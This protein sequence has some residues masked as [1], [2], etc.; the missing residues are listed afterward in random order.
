MIPLKSQVFCFFKVASLSHQAAVILCSFPLKGLSLTAN[1]RV[2]QRE[3]VFVWLGGHCM[4]LWCPRKIFKCLALINKFTRVQGWE[5]LYLS[6]LHLVPNW[7]AEVS[8]CTSFNCLIM[9]SLAGLFLLSIG[10]RKP[11]KT[12]RRSQQRRESK[13]R[14][15]MP[16]VWWELICIQRPNGI[17]QKPL[18]LVSQLKS[19]CWIFLWFLPTEGEA[20]TEGSQ[21]VLQLSRMISGRAEEARTGGGAP[22]RVQGPI[23]PAVTTCLSSTG[24]YPLFTVRTHNKTWSD[25]YYSHYRICAP[26]TALDI[27]SPSPVLHRLRFEAFLAQP[28]LAKTIGRRSRSEGSHKGQRVDLIHAA[29]R[30]PWVPSLWKVSRVQRD[31]QQSQLTHPQTSFWTSSEARETVSF[32]NCIRWRMC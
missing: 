12:S 6:W 5:A 14:R 28:Q 9:L 4:A 13:P 18:F 21:R 16:T 26:L 17:S 29:W 2:D 3:C 30:D 25:F 1:S 27:P 23:H 7:F 22:G 11:K 8:L 19:M 31:A 15:S 24:P 20:A 32:P 10:W